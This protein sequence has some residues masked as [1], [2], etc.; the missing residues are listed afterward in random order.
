MLSRMVFALVAGVLMVRSGFAEEA[1]IASTAVT[2]PPPEGFC[3]MTEQEPSDNR[4]IQALAGMLAHAKIEPLS[5]SADCAQLEAWRGGLRPLLDDFA[6]YQTPISLKESSFPRDQA[7]EETCKVLR[8]QGGLVEGMTGD[9]N[10]RLKTVM[11]EAKFNELKFLGVLNQGADACYFGLLQK[12][13]TQPGT[14][15]TQVSVTAITA[16]NGK[17][18]NYVLSAAYQNE[19]T[20]PA[21]LARHQRNVAA[22]FAANGG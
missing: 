18:V 2:L 5:L 12:L 1:S 8:A 11:E 9:L 21:L 19:D 16:V 20:V 15:K 14:Q 13:Q 7:I 4:M 10:A 22:L 17:L 6:Q 3:D